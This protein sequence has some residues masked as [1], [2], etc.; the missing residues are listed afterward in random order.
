MKNTFLSEFSFLLI[1]K[2]DR[3]VIW[4]RGFE[5]Q[6]ANSEQCIQVPADLWRGKKKLREE[7]NNGTLQHL[8]GL[9]PHFPAPHLRLLL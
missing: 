2:R 7:T 6:S 8:W 1:L 4:G 3:H 5:P 9:S